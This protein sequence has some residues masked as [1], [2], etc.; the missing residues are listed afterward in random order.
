MLAAMWRRALKKKKKLSWLCVLLIRRGALRMC[1]GSVVIE[2][3]HTHTFKYYMPT[4]ES[5]TGAGVV[6]TPPPPHK[7]RD[8]RQKKL[9]VSGEKGTIFSCGAPYVI[10][11]HT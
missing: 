10:P 4:L 11:P 1:E 7:G 5:H 8:K 9:K 3:V 2:Q 6:Y